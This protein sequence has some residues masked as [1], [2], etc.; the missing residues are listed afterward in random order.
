M[1]C[2]LLTKHDDRNLMHRL[3]EI[4]WYI[5]DVTDFI[6]PIKKYCVPRLIRFFELKLYYSYLIDLLDSFGYFTDIFRTICIAIDQSDYSLLEKLSSIPLKV[7]EEEAVNLVP[8]LQSIL[9]DLSE[10]KDEKLRSRL[11]KLISY[12]ETRLR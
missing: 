7:Y 5:S 11:E 8:K 2:L 10:K 1:I 6:T 9:N 4:L 12:V 3:L